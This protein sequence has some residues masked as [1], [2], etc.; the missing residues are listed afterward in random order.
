MAKS[1]RFEQIWRSRKSKKELVQEEPLRETCH[2]YDIERVDVQES[3]KD[4][5]ETPYVFFL[6]YTL[7]FFCSMSS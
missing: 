6:E 5:H 1:A 7:V 4:V 3:K 2:L